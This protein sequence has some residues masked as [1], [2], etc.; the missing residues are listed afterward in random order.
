[1]RCLNPAEPLPGRLS[2]QAQFRLV[3]AAA[4]ARKEKLHRTRRKAAGLTGCAVRHTGNVCHQPWAAKLARSGS[5]RQSIDMVR[6]ES[7]ARL[8]PAVRHIPLSGVR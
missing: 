5:Q 6:E 8:Y 7:P 1:M 2:P 3:S 4:P